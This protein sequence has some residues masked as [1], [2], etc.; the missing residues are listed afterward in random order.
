VV[1]VGRGKTR[2]ISVIG[3]LKNPAEFAGLLAASNVF[4]LTRKQVI[5]ELPQTIHT[6]VRCGKAV[7]VRGLAGPEEIPKARIEEAASRFEM[8]ASDIEGIKCVVFCWFRETANGFVRSLGS[9][10]EVYFCTGDT[11]PEGR[12]L[13]I[14]E[15]K[16]SGKGVL[17]ATIASASLGLDFSC[18]RDCFFL[19]GV[20]TEAGMAQARDRL[21]RIG[22]TD[23]ISY[24]YYFADKGVEQAV[25]LISRGRRDEVSEVLAGLIGAAGR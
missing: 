9:R 18:A 7:N 13:I 5:T 15:W 24:N 12:G 14:E 16:R 10:E 20:H 25:H 23:P 6:D 8:V 4:T 1:R 11:S 21:V 17:V 22:Q 3:E 19:E 2:T